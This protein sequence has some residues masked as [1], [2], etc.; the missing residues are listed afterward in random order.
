MRFCQYGDEYCAW[1]DRK[2]M[3]CYLF[4]GS[5]RYMKGSRLDLLEREVFRLRNDVDM[6][7]KETETLRDNPLVFDEEE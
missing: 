6:L 2:C 5:Q 4:P 7:I 3:D 1:P